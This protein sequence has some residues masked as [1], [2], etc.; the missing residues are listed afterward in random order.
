MLPRSLR[1]RLVM[2]F[3]VGTSAVVTL[4][5]VAIYAT[6]NA[7]IDRMHSARW[8]HEYLDRLKA[9]L[10][11]HPEAAT[12]EMQTWVAWVEQYTERS[13]PFVPHAK[14]PKDPKPWG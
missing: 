3:V 12:E 9:N 1:G 10:K 13:D 6:L 7:E 14:V 8:A 5:S 11:A 2:L 4:S